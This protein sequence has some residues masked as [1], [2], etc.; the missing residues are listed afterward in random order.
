MRGQRH[1]LHQGQPELILQEFV[2]S[3]KL[4]G[5]GNTFPDSRKEAESEDRTDLSEWNST[6]SAGSPANPAA[7]LRRG[8]LRRSTSRESPRDHGCSDEQIIALSHKRRQE[9]VMAGLPSAPYMTNINTGL[10]SLTGRR[11]VG[12]S[13]LRPS[14]TPS[15]SDHPP[16]LPEWAAYPTLVFSVQLTEAAPEARGFSPSS[17]I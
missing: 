2:T 11:L 12:K 6:P 8:F 16:L 3:V 17:L 9:S 1:Q 7:C 13:I 14:P 10:I 4:V 5:D 15:D